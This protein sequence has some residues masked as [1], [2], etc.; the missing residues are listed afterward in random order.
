M[1]ASIRAVFLTATLLLS[2]FHLALAED[3]YC[4]KG[5][6]GRGVGTIP[7]SCDSAKR[8]ESGLCYPACP[9]GYGGAGPVC[10]ANCPAGYYDHGAGCTKPAPY[11]RGGGYAWHLGDGLN[12][13]GMY[14]RCEHDNGRGGCEKWGAVVY[15]KC[16]AGF[17]TVGCCVC[18]PDCPS[19]YTDTGATCTKP[20]KTRGAGTIPTSC[21]GNKQ[22]DAGLCYDH[23]KG[24]YNGVG[25]VCWNTCPKGYVDCA[26]GCAT[27]SSYCAQVTADQVTSTIMLA[28][29]V[30]TMGASGEV[31]AAAKSA[32]EATRLAKAV[33][34]AKEAWAALKASKEYVRLKQTAQGVAYIHKMEKLAESKT[35]EEA[36][37]A[38]AGFDPTGLS[39]VVSAYTQKICNN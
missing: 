1:R 4:Y 14:N 5:S 12:D 29:N 17:H 24:G 33:N 39:Q 9:S 20:T 34:D 25:P 22:N 37:R 21:D 8:N 30:A 3:D 36:A 38:M 18:S 6:Y 32:E 13:G 2:A 16:R 28:V 11:G 7:T 31:E 15:P 23:C 19:G 10:W 26:A 35:A 27:S